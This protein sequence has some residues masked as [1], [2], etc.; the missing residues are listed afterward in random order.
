MCDFHQGKRL[1]D[2]IASIGAGVICNS[3]E[4]LV[5]LGR[6]LQVHP[7]L[8]VLFTSHWRLS[9]M[10]S[11]RYSRAHTNSTKNVDRIVRKASPISTERALNFLNMTFGRVRKSAQ[12]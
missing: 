1:A 3:L 4:Q 12:D 9:R 2:Y 11:A 8:L 10:W 6:N 5:Q 7:H